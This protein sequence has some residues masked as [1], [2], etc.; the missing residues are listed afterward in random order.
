MPNALPGKAAKKVA[1]KAA[2]KTPAK[3]PHKAAKKV[4][5]GPGEDARKAYEHLCRLRSMGQLLS[6]EATTQVELLSRYAQGAFATGEA[7]AAA[8]LLRAAEHLA[9]AQMQH[10]TNTDS[11]SKELKQALKAELDHRL[12]RAAEHWDAQEAKPSP[13][14]KQLYQSLRRAAKNL[15][16]EG[17]YAGALES[18]RAADALAHAAPAGLRLPGG[19]E[20][21]TPSPLLLG[22]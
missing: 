3:A 9:F 15:W 8:D 22:F 16:S 14:I 5:K 18:A 2:K 4:A 11:P 21:G 7:R 20:T 12:E 6:E 1:K 17:A 19:E 10:P 13:E